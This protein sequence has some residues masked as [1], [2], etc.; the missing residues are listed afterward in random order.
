M[1]FLSSIGSRIGRLLGRPR[2][3][4]E[5]EFKTHR[6]ESFDQVTLSGACYVPMLGF[7]NTIHYRD[8]QNL[9]HLG[10]YE[11]AVRV[12]SSLPNRGAVL[13]C[14]CGVGYGSRKLAEIFERVDAVDIYDRAIELAK[15]RYSGPRIEWNCLDAAKIREAFADESFDAVVS[16]QTIESIEDDAKYLDDLVALLKPGGV[17]L[18]DTP[19]RKSRIDNPE[20]PH[21]KRYYGLHEWLQMLQNR[22]EILVFATLPEAKMLEDC[23]M[24]S[25]GSIVHCTKSD[26]LSEAAFEPVSGGNN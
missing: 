15:E 7:E 8:K 18:I 20:N 11:W 17:L 25:R 14:A 2:Q 3:I 9:H 16:M 12:L 1:A 10:R 23:Q 6:R 5:E 19:L 4:S 21:H 24:P 13:D 22:F 26:P